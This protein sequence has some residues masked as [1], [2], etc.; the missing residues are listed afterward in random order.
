MADAQHPWNEAQLVAY[1]TGKV[2]EDHGA[3][4]GPMLPVSLSIAQLPVED[5]QAIARYILDLKKPR[6]T[7]RHRPARLRPIPLP[8]RCRCGAVRGCL[9]KLPQ[10]RRPHAHP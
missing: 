9:R 4:A 3:A 1:L 5:A 2:A 7:P 8:G 10:L 6:R